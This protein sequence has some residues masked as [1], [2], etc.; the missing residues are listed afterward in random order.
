[1]F[2]IFR[3]VLAI[4]VA[5]SHFGIRFKGLNPGQWAVIAF[6]LLSGFLMQKQAEKLC[7]N[8]KKAPF[9]L[10]RLIRIGPLYFIVMLLATPLFIGTW[11]D[12]SQNICLFPLNYAMFTNVPILIGPA[13]SLACEAHFYLLI[14]IIFHFKERSLKILCCVSLLIFALSPSLPHTTFWAYTGLPGIFFVFASG[15][16]I[17]KDQL[18][19]VRKIWIILF[20]LL[21]VF[22]LLKMFIPSIPAGINI[23]VSLGFVLLFPVFLFL[24]HLPSSNKFDRKIGLLSYPLFLCHEPVAHYIRQLW[25]SQNAAIYLSA[26][27]LVAILLVICVEVPFDKIR[28]AIR[29][30]RR[31]EMRRSHEADPVSLL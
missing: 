19:F 14:P 12:Y 23:N 8:D 5:L 1:M 30:N 26:S 9:Y 7:S 22:S 10:D 6:Y 31:T 4:M 13:W 17:A 16:L 29:K 28:Y 15:M 20:V 21:V 18:S 11:V 27:L 24:S 25:G 2:G 3:L